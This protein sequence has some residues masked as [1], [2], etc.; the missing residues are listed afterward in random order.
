M[1]AIKAFLL[2]VM[3]FCSDFTTNPGEGLI[4]TY[5]R[6]R[7]FAHRLTFRHFDH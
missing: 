6:G 5:D 2:G 7:D 4:E 1:N 3:E